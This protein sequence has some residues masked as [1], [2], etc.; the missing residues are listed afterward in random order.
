[1]FGRRATVGL[2]LLC[3]L[4]F[5]AIAVQSA[6]AVPSN[7]TTAVTCV[8][9]KGVLE[10]EDPHCDDY[11]GPGNGDYG[12]IPIDAV[13][14]T[15]TEIETSNI[16]TGG[17]T[18]PAVLAGEVGGAKIEIECTVA[19]GTGTVTNTE[20]PAGSK[21]H[22]VDTK[23]GKKLTKCAVKKPA[24]CTIKEPIE[25]K[26]EGEGVDELEGKKEMGVEF[27]PEGG[28]K[29][30]ATITLEGAECALK[31]KSLNLEGTMISTSGSGSNTNKW[32]GATTEFTKA[33]TEKTLV[34]GGKPASFTATTT[35][36]MKGGEP[37]ALTT[38]TGG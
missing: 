13:N 31:G 16:S 38:A 23:G 17:S 15:A 5:S 14:G 28:G 20:E 10:F 34:L 8:K 35:V 9:E 19:A 32:S 22:K 21:K 29:T 26:L 2:S 6:A 11:V 18:V 27:K 4:L 24:K 7:N 36:R 3:A 25:F 1:M 12:H 37:I 33:M 30:I